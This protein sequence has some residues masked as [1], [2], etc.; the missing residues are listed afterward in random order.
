MMIFQQW[1][2][3]QKTGDR[4][5]RCLDCASVFAEATPDRRDAEGELPKLTHDYIE[6]LPSSPSLRQTGYQ[7]ERIL[8]L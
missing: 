2:F 3:R 6:E 8:A 4:R 5:K 7:A 1:R